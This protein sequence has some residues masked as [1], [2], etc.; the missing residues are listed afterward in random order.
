M[1]Y[2]VPTDIGSSL[3]VIPPDTYEAEITDIKFGES[4]QGKPKCTIIFTLKSDFTGLKGDDFQSCI[5]EKVID[6]VSLQPQAMFRIND[7]FKAATGDRIPA[8]ED[9]YDKDEFEELINENLIG[10]NMAILLETDTSQGDERTK[11]KKLTALKKSVK[12]SGLGG[13]KLKR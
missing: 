8:N 4:A 1:K 6:T 5:G 11:V 9:G 7:Y 12:T 13:R 10:A 3:R 2:V